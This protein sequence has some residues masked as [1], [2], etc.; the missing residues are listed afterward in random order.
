MIHSDRLETPADAGYRKQRRRLRWLVLTAIIAFVG[1]VYWMYFVQVPKEYALD[2]DHFLHGSIGSDN[3]AGIPISI[4]K[5]LP[6][7]FPEYLPG[8]GREYL[9]I[10]AAKVA[11]G[12][13]VDHRDGYASF[14]FLMREGHDLPV[15]FSQRRYRIDLVGLNCAICHTG[16]LAVEN[17]LQADAIYNHALPTEYIG[18]PGGQGAGHVLIYGMPAHSMDLEAYFTFLFRCAEDPRFNESNLL[19][20]MDAAANRGA[21]PKVSGVERALTKI[22]VRELRKTLLERRQQLHYLSGLAHHPGAPVVP[23]Y[24]PGRID[25]FS[26]YKSIQFGFPFDGTYGIA[27]YPSIWNQ[28]PREGMHLHWDGNNSSVFERNISASIGAGVTPVSIDMPRMLRVARWIGAPPPE[29]SGMDYVFRDQATSGADPFQP[30]IG[31]MPIPQYPFPVDRVL[32]ARGQKLFSAYC[33]R[34]HG[35]WTSNASARTK[36][37]PLTDPLP[38]VGQVVPL[39][40]IG[41]D[42]ARLESYTEALRNNQYRLGSSQWWQ[43]SNF[44]KT[45]GYANSPLDGV[46]ARAPY[47]HN[48]SVPSLFDLFSRPCTPEDLVKLG[49]DA[50]TDLNQLAAD[51]ERVGKLIAQAR[52]MRVRPPVFYRGDDQ[53][54]PTHVGFRCDRAHGDDG[55]ATFFYSTIRQVDGRFETLY[56]NGHQGHYRQTFSDGASYGDELPMDELWALI[57]F[58][59]LVGS[60]RDKV[61]LP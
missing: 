28:R 55:R 15:G 30:F 43:F 22:G 38:V 18:A 8:E 26:P 5:V 17:R 53:Y 25:T 61:V 34:C 9:K 3:A 47:L 13:T 39:P 57:E 36:D 41:T 20:A 10:K 46:W 19:S 31:E 21:A 40:E 48:G 6:D 33:A 35:D 11:A 54:D 45:N 1:F 32:A 14:G 16:T 2:S 42:G 23:R 27:D 29:N 56:G 12:Q 37:L 7:T 58:Q 4:W 50:R 24:G 60:P 52:T 44:R 59:K 49:I 51:P